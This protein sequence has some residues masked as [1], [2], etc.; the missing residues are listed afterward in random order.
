MS[1]KWTV[2]FQV[3]SLTLLV[4]M[5]YTELSVSSA[6][7]PKWISDVLSSPQLIQ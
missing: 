5:N 4:S 6:N 2:I 7:T 3:H 1:Y